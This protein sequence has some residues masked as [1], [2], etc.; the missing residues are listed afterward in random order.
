MT[1]LTE[2]ARAGQGLGTTRRE[3]GPESR[4]R[5]GLFLRVR[6]GESQLF[7]A[8]ADELGSLLRRRLRC[9]ARTRALGRNPADVEDV[10]Q[11]TFLRLWEH[12]A[13]F[14]PARG[15]VD[16]WAWSIARNAAVDV[17]RR[18]SRTVTNTALPDAVEDWRAAGPVGELVAAEARRAFAEAL[19]RVTNPTA[20]RV[21]ELRLV[22]GLPYAAVSQATGVPPGTVAT[23]VHGLRRALRAAVLGTAT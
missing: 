8:L 9:D 19:G 17:L 23:W 16:M 12:R 21:L 4:R 7:G 11:T 2:H 14:D 22:A 18:R 15:A 3:P 13:R 1:R 6:D 20:R 5:T 10:L